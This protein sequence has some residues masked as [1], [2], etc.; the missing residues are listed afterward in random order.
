MQHVYEK[1]DIPCIN[2]MLYSNQFVL[3]WVLKFLVCSRIGAKVL[4]FDFSAEKTQEANLLNE[5]R[6]RRF[7]TRHQGIN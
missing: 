6:S 1:H 4:F 2:Y 7:F 5:V 3:F